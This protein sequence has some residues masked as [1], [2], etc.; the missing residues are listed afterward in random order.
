MEGAL[1]ALLSR[2]MERQHAVQ[3]DALR[4]LRLVAPEGRRDKTLLAWQGLHD[5]LC[6]HM[7]Q[8]EDVLMP[9]YRLHAADLPPNARPHVLAA[10]HSR[11]RALLGQVH[12][13]AGADDA[14]GAR[15]ELQSL[16]LLAGVLEHHDLREKAWFVP[17]LEAA[18]AEETRARWVVEFEAEAPPLPVAPAPQ[19]AHPP[20]EEESGV[21]AFLATVARDGPVGT[22][23][24]HMEVPEG[25]RGQ[26]L[27]QACG[28]LTA[29]VEAATSLVQRRECLVALA[30]RARLLG[31]V[32]AHPPA[33]A[34]DRG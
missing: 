16:A 29:R 2:W 23:F 22:A 31:I 15:C 30:D 32:A 11:I 4:A 28:E 20:L 3:D 5:Q 27:Y 34:T 19:W 13:A 7:A 9:V 18:V 12:A 14:V 26:A 1:D 17:T 24:A 10:D 21:E 8:E 6:C 25:R 33:D